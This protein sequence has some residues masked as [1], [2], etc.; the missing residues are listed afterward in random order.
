MGCYIYVALD[1]DD[2]AALPPRGKRKT[3]LLEAFNVHANGHARSGDP[4]NGKVD[5]RYYPGIMREGELRETTLDLPVS[6]LQC[7]VDT[8]RGRASA[9]E[10]EII[11]LTAD[12]LRMHRHNFK[13][14]SEPFAGWMAAK[15]APGAQGRDVQRHDLF[16]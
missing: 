14:R 12:G 10:G 13:T 11:N 9:A 4:E 16:I 5:I 6:A 15:V 2:A 8:R 3:V 1:F 7:L